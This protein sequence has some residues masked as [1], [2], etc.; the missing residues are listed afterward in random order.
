MMN[1]QSGMIVIC[2]DADNV[3][4]YVKKNAAYVVN[5]VSHR[6]NLL[7]LEGVGITLASCRFVPASSTPQS[8]SELANASNQ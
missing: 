1:I 7:S 2:Q 8:E 3:E 5:K 4:K 6:G